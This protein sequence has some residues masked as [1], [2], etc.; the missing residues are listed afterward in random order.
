MEERR[1]D[2]LYRLASVGVRVP[3]PYLVHE[4]VLLMELVRTRRAIRRRGST[5]WRSAPKWRASG[6]RS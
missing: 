3:K 4:G 2:A 1:G 5:M 6:M